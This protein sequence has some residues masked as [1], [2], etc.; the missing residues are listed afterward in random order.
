MSAG[1]G[2][3]LA[4]TL[5][6]TL[7][8]APLILGS[9]LF[10]GHEVP[11]RIKVGGQHA[12]SIH[13]LPGGGRIIDAM[14]PDEGAISWTGYF[15]GPSAAARARVVDAIRQNGDLVGLSFGDYAFNVVVVHF[16]YDIQDRGAVISYRIRAEILPSTT[17]PVNDTA[18]AIATSI[19]NDLLTAASLLPGSA[20]G[21]S[22]SQAQVVIAA[23]SAPTATQT[24]ALVGNALSAG[25][26][27][28]QAALSMTG[29]G[30]VTGGANF[31]TAGT[32][33]PSLDGLAQ[34]AG[35]L[36]AMTQSAGYVNRSQSNLNQ[37]AGLPQGDPLIFA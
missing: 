22:L 26:S 18:G 24:L 19:S 4:D 16:D 28:L 2:L 30:L 36:A 1:F 35:S 37:L 27:A 29:A 3:A 5:L 10:Y 20:A 34:D 8:Q 21:S 32:S 14:G 23:A 13:R 17:S 6:A 9:V 31:G 12:V 33:Q 11:A 7:E 25:G 15:T